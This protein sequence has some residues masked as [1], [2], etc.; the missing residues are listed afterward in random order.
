MKLKNC[1]LSA[2]VFSLVL[3]GEAVAQTTRGGMVDSSLVARRTTVAVRYPEKEKTEVAMIGTPLAPRISGE[4]EVKRTEGRTRVKVE[5]KNV[6]HPQT[7]GA[8]YT[9]YVL[10][11]IAPEGQADNLGEFP[12]TRGHGKSIEVTTPYSTFGLI[13]TAEPYGLVKLPS[14]AVV[15]ENALKEKTKGTV[16]MSRIEYRGDAGS[17]Y[18]VDDT[19]TAA[20]QAALTPDFTTPLYVLSARRAAEVARRAGAE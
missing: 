20:G 5:L 19:Q 4:A 2:L 3:A 11:A 13:V 10:W 12:I 18:V 17:F 14:P 1:M 7:L 9:T 16:E 6:E 8:F 15:A